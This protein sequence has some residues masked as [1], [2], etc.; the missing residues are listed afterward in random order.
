VVESFWVC[1]PPTQGIT[2]LEIMGILDRFDLASI[3]EGSA[4]YYHLLVEAVKFAFIDRNRYVADPEFVDVPVGKMLSKENL[5]SHAKRIDMAKAQQWPYVFKPGDTVFLAAADSQGHCVSALE[6]IYFDW[7]S[8][9]VVSDT[10]ILWH[11]RGASFTLDP[12]HHNVLK[13]GKRP[14]HTLNPG[15]YVKDGRPAILYGTQGADGQP[16]TLAAVLT[17]LI[18]YKM[19]PLRALEHPRFL[20]GKTFSDTRDSLKL[21]QDAGE[22]VFKALAARGHEMSPIPAQSPLAGHPGAIR[23]EADGSMVG[24]HDPRSDGLA[25]GL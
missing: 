8:G 19:D 12:K 9:V 13:P 25:L 6:T 1:R 16:Q 20:L 24:A 23:I 2:T 3:P 4:D 7:G 21:E 11:N 22:A 17:R 14:F 15:I 18:D 5:D 10:G